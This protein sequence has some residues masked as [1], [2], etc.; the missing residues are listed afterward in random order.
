MFLFHVNY[1]II[2]SATMTGARA[3]ALRC[4]HVGWLA[5]SFTRT[6]QMKDDFMV[7]QYANCQVETAKKQ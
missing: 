5:L 2:I 1:N 6:K 7:T 4:V 3:A